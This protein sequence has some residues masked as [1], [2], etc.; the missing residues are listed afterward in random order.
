MILSS[1]PRQLT[2]PLDLI[3]LVP[4][5]PTIEPFSFS[6]HGFNSGSSAK[7][8]CA[9]TSGDSP[10]DV[11]WL[12]NGQRLDDSYA[13]RLDEFSSFLS[14]RLVTISDAGNYTCVARNRAGTTEYTSALVVKGG[15]V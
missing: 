12:K 10:M 2:H 5:L 3:P 13:K 8:M 6:A 7:T 1:I 9:V 11:F 15:L 14:F 4:E